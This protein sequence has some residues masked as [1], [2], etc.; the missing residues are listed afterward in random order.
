MSNGENLGQDGVLLKFVVQLEKLE[1]KLKTGREHM[2]GGRKP[3]LGQ[4]ES[5]EK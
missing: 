5:G 1:A 4:V 3:S 2:R